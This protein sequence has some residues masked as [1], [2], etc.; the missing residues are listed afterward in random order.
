MEWSGLLVQKDLY[1]FTCKAE[2]GDN[3]SLPSCFHYQKTSSFL[4]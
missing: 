2:T 4:G 3:K 1:D